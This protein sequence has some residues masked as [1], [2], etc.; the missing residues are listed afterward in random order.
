MLCGLLIN[1]DVDRKI[2]QNVMTV[3][4]LEFIT[5]DICSIALDF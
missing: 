1:R 4:R 5:T 2:F 3:Q